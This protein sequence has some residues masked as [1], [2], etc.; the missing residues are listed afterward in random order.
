MSR[1]APADRSARGSISLAIFLR[2]QNLISTSNN[3]PALARFITSWEK[4]GF[5]KIG[6]RG[7]FHY[8][9]QT[10]RL[11]NKL[12]RDIV[13]VEVSPAGV[14]LFPDV[15]MIDVIGQAALGMEELVLVILFIIALA[16]G[17]PQVIFSS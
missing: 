6:G 11:S 7:N 1:L 17:D 5:S 15:R 14:A 9:S 4:V 8:P 16:P 2:P 12:E 13:L 10:P 3:F